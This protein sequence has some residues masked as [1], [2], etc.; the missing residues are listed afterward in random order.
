MLSSSSFKIVIKKEINF[1]V[2]IKC[3]TVLVKAVISMLAATR[4]G[5]I[6]VV[7]FGGFAAKELSVRIEHCKPK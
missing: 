7:V 4:L 6:H 3:I 1:N 2:N 5:A